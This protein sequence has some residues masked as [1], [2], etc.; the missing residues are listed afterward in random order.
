MYFLFTE[1]TTLRGD[2]TVELACSILSSPDPSGGC[3]GAIIPDTKKRKSP[4][5]KRQC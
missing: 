4:V 2:G 3:R 1:L 5:E